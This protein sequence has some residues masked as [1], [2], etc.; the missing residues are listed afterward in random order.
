MWIFIVPVIG[1]IAL[2][3]F[4]L[5]NSMQIINGFNGVRHR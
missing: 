5:R 2:V 1:V 4:L 3:A